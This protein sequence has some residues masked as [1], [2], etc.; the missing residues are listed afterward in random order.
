MKKYFQKKV[1]KRLKK[2]DSNFNLW[3]NFFNFS[4][5]LGLNNF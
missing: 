4:N 1:K 3:T 5:Q 2:I